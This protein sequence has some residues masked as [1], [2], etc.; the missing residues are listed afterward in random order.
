MRYEHGYAKWTFLALMF[1]FFVSPHR[2]AQAQAAWR[3]AKHVELIVPAAGGSND[4]IARVVQRIMQDGKPAATPIVV[5]NKA[6]GNQSI[7]P[8]Y[9]SQYAGDPHYLLLANPTL[10]AN[11]LSAITPLN[12]TDFTPVA[13]LLREHTVFSVRS[14]SPIK[15]MRDAFE[16][17]KADPDSIAIGVA[18]LGGANYLA[19]A[20]SA[21]AAGIDPRRL[22]T[23][24]FKSSAESMT[25]MLGGHVQLVASSLSLASGHVKAGNAHILGTASP[26]RTTGAHADVATLAEQGIE[27][28]VSSSWRGVFGPKGMTEAQIAYWEN[29][30]SKV[31]VS[32]EW[33][34]TLE[35][36]FWDGSFLGSRDF[37]KYLAVEYEATRAIMT[38]LGLAR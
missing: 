24:V 21:K 25:A 13:L 3:P 14:D 4:Q 11:H 5:V 31:A 23:V 33:K 22:K 35:V 12:Y 1:L 8:T 32:E 26:Q 34:K 10:F 9:L 18:S 36:R 28:Q 15:N 17:L 20:Q 37:T 29:A 38:E 16:R 30:L 7:A 2:E 27:A 6:G 19:L